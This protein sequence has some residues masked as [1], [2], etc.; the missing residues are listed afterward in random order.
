MARTLCCRFSIPVYHPLVGSDT[1]HTHQG[2]TKSSTPTPCVRRHTPTPD[3]TRDGNTALHCASKAFKA[4]IRAL[5]EYRSTSN[6]VRASLRSRKYGTQPYY[7]LPLPKFH[8]RIRPFS[9]QR[10]SSSASGKPAINLRI[11]I[12]R[13]SQHWPTASNRTTHGD[14][15]PQAAAFLRQPPRDLRLARRIRMRD[16]GD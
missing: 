5:C 1:P 7:P 2:V 3:A 9:Y 13:Y 12:P 10:E 11:P 16:Y 4:I 8:F 14:Q 15:D 6:T